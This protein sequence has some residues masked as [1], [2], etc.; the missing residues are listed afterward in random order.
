MAAPAFFAAKP[1]P[2]AMPPRRDDIVP[3][4]SSRPILML[5]AV[6]AALAAV[7]AWLVF[8]VTFVRSG[9]I[10]LNFNAVGADWM[11]FHGAARSYLDGHLAT[12]FDGTRF[13]AY[14]NRS[15]APW[16]SMKLPFR[17]WVYPPSYLLLVAPF[18]LLGFLSSYVLFQA[19]A[20]AALVA[21]IVVGAEDRDR[22]MSW[23][24][25]AGAVLCPAA[26]DSAA[27]GQNV[28]LIAALLVA[29]VRMLD[30]RPVLAGVI[31]GLL[32]IKP[33]FAVM[34]PIALLA[35]R[36][37]RALFAAAAAALVLV[38]VS[39]VVFGVDAWT[40]WLQQTIG[41]LVAPDSQWTIYGRMW[42]CSIWTCAVLLGASSSVASMLQ[43]GGVLLAGG[44]VVIV[45]RRPADAFDRIAVL[46]AA[47]VLAAPYW[48]FYDAVLLAL[49][50][51]CWLARQDRREPA[52][53]PWM[54]ALA[55]WV[56]PLVSP[57]LV[58]PAGRLGPLLIVVFIVAAVW[59]RSA[60]RLDGDLR[61]HL[62][63]PARR[64]MEE[65]GRIG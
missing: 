56:L 34:A 31:L 59:S 45:F 30:A 6:T 13:T 37:W 15:Y 10:G 5:L 26:A 60:R 9:A 23:A 55:L 42:G 1:P 43:L 7:Y 57:P 32:T 33:Q 51:L 4:G 35:A 12:I 17:P 50:A 64:D 53:W 39:A 11:V 41:N 46:L 3:D 49:A 19:L 28:F 21:A 2:K 20:A 29:G 61:P 25:A 18:G 63:H 40:I 58:A 65:V 22:R 52:L 54:L 47:T 48:S 38:A 24:I 14:L 36:Q 44:A 27:S 8:A 16:L 62:Q